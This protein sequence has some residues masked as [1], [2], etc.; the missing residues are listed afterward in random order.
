MSGFGLWVVESVESVGSIES[1]LKMKIE[2]FEDIEAWK[3]ARSLTKDIYRTLNK[4]LKSINDYR[5]KAQITSSAVSIMA[6]IAEGFCRKSDKEFSQF[7]FISKASVAELQSH[8]Y[9]ALDLEYIQ[10]PEFEAFYK[11]TDKI[12]R[13]ISRF[14]SYLK[15]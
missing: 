13:L 11:S 3:E 10:Q 14:I 6:N 4:N 9:V 2:K 7:L 5:F 1:K 15:N 12:A 8:L